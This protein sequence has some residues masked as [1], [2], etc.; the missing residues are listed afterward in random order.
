MADKQSSH[1]PAQTPK[2][3][4]AARKQARLSQALKANMARRKTQARARAT[5]TSEGSTTGTAQTAQ[6]KES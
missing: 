1:T 2:A 5:D 4:E 3:A 6:D